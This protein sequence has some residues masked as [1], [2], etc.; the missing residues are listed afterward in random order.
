DLRGE[1]LRREGYEFPGGGSAHYDTFVPQHFHPYCMRLIRSSAVALGFL[2]SV[3]L[4]ACGGG[5]GGTD[6]TAVGPAAAV[7][8]VSGSSASITAGSTTPIPLVAKVTD[9]GGHAVA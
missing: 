8:A 7:A 2:F 5:G 4:A 3:L 9:A 1:R 6:A